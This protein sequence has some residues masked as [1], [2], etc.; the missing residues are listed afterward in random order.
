MFYLFFRIVQKGNAVQMLRVGQKRRRTHKEKLA[1]EAEA[2]AKE[3]DIQAKL[4]RLEQM[5]REHEEFKQ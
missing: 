2:R 5:E 3:E 1:D 4:A